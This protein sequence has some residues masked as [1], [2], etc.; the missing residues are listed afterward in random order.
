MPG[1][2][3]SLCRIVQQVQCLVLVQSG[4]LLAA[5]F[6]YV[7][8]RLAVIL[9]TG[10]RWEALLSSVELYYEKKHADQFYIAGL[11]LFGVFIR[12]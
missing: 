8:L 12:L 4:L 2:L 10:T 9:N 3:Y 5:N 6:F 7:Q 1:S 11:L